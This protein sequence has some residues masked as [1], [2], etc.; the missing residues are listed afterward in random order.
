LPY[1]GLPLRSGDESVPIDLNALM[2]VVYESAA[3]DGMID[4]S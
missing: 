3:L 2:Q 4:R 1:F